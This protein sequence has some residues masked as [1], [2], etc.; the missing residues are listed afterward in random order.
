MN[1]I[2]V[3]GDAFK[4]MLSHIKPEAR[5]KELTEEVKTVK[6]ISKKDALIKQIKYLDGLIK[7]EL[8]PDKAYV[9]SHMP[10]IPPQ[11]RPASVM[12][13]NRI[14]FADVNTLYKDH[15]TVNNSL[16]DIKDMLPPEELIEERSQAFN[17]VKAVLGL[18]EP[19]SPN[20]KGRNLRGLLRQVS[21]V[22]GPKTGLF[23]SKL[24]SKKQDF[25]GRGTIYSNP[26][27]KFN[28]ATVPV[29][30]LWT[31]Y[32]LH[33]LRDLAKKG[34]DY[35]NAEKAW[36]ERTPAA[37]A[38]F[39]KLIQEIPI[40]INRAP[41]LMKS[42][43]SAVYP[44]PTTNNAIGINPLHL[45]AFAGDYDGDSFSMYLSMTPQAIK[46]V[47]ENVLME[48]QVHDY[49]K[50]LN[51]SLMAPGHEAILGSMHMTEPD[52]TQA[53]VKFKTEEACL[54][55]LK[56]GKIKENTPVEIG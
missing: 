26:E 39:N 46:E 44:V 16:K 55:A 45:P 52:A 40:M 4:A 38:S 22:S 53:I 25:S 12:G 56:E 49:R 13:G 15:M 19:I 1:D 34:Y 24:L 3:S 28:E 9:I 41:T 8:Q 31:M 36:T 11:M 32:K 27:L 48:N 33:I 43:V 2:L 10:V 51:S 6:S 42:N 23:H 18:G 54:Q 47:K 20:A 30:Q 35:V 14:E 17:G 37:T 7:T 5:L 21:G 50:G 29:D